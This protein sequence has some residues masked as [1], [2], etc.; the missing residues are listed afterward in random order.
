MSAKNELWNF[1]AH[2]CLHSKIYPSKLRDC[3]QN[4]SSDLNV[5]IEKS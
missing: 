2:G 1:K 4:S 5:N 3:R